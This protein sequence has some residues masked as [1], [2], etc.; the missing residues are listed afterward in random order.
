MAESV[1][2]PLRMTAREF[3]TC[4]AVMA[5]SGKPKRKVPHRPKFI[6]LRREPIEGKFR[7]A[8]NE[9]GERVKAPVFHI[10]TT[11]VNTSRLYR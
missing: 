3:V 8:R 7:W 2:T 11:K 6:E 5:Q 9:K 4:L 10:T 1:K